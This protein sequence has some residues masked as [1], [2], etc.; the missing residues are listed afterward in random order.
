[1]FGNL[2]LISVPRKSHFI[3]QLSYLAGWRALR[4]LSQAQLLAH[5]DGAVPF[6]L[7]SLRWLSQTH[8]RQEGRLGVRRRVFTGAGTGSS[9]SL[10]PFVD[11]YSLKLVCSLYFQMCDLTGDCLC[12]IHYACLSQAVTCEL[13]SE[14]VFASSKLLINALNSARLRSIPWE[15]ARSIAARFNHFK[16]TAYA[17]HWFYV[18]L[19]KMWDM[20]SS[21]SLKSQTS[22]SS[23]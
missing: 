6:A 16:S 12:L 8:S 9:G 4:S 5:R 19:I 14:R 3:F 1:M 22:R 11:T 13:S 20:K 17:S 18:L 23:L 21:V 7:S 10:F 15:S 2:C